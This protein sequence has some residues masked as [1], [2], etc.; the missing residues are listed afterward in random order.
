[1]APALTFLL[2]VYGAV[3]SSTDPRM[4]CGTSRVTMEWAG[5]GLLIVRREPQCVWRAGNQGAT[6]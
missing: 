3:G 6:R 4:Q 5:W 1:M 2:A